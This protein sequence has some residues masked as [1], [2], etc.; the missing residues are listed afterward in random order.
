MANS[1]GVRTF[2]TPFGRYFFHRLP[3]RI[4]SAP[5][6][7]QREMNNL[8]RD[9]E[10]TAVNMDG[11]IIYGEKPEVH[12]CRLRRVLK[13]LSDAGLKLN[14]G[15]CLLRQTQIKLLGY[16]IDARGGEYSTSTE[17]DRSKEDFGNGSLSRSIPTWLG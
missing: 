1:T 12:D 3:F 9:H 2:I 15:K 13:T 14:D 11:I 6:I 10:G 5:E 8:L 17:R 4:S 16:I 7:F